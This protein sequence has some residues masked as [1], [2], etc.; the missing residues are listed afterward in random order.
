MPKVNL[1]FNQLSRASRVILKE[2][3]Y[4]VLNQ[5]AKPEGENK[6]KFS[7]EVEILTKLGG[8]ACRFKVNSKEIEGHVDLGIQSVG[9]H[10]LNPYFVFRAPRSTGSLGCFNSGTV[11]TVFHYTPQALSYWARYHGDLTVTPAIDGGGAS[12]RPE[13]QIR[14]NFVVGWRNFLFGASENWTFRNGF[15]RTGKLSVAINQ[16]KYSTPEYNAFL[17]L[18]LKDPLDLTTVTAGGW[19][20]ACREAK[21]YAQYSL[22][23]PKKQWELGAGVD[24]SLR[25]GVGAKLGYFHN[26]KIS[27]ALSFKLNRYF[28]GSLL[29]D[30]H[31][32]YGR[33]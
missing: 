8:N 10:S 32:F 7:E 17:E 6:L 13:I 30:V 9:E 3:W 28:T 18:D 25:A 24:V 4:R 20:Q 29:F 19:Y 11:G 1:S 31:S 26:Q 22:N 14:E 16:Q 23:L 5:I 27:S 15:N 2:S 33:S 12:D 21:I